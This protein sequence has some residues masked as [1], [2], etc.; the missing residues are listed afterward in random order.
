MN[1]VVSRGD[2][3]DDEYA[4][5]LATRM[6]RREKVYAD[7]ARRPRKGNSHPGRLDPSHADLVLNALLYER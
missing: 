5:A 1:G 4:K 6:E 3:T 2:K 7:H